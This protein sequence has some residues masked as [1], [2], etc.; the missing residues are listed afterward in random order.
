MNTNP[1]KSPAELLGEIG[2]KVKQRRLHEGLTQATLADKAG[3]SR[4]SL[5]ELEAGRGSQLETFVRVL[6]AMGLDDNLAATIP[7]PRVSPMSMLNA[8]K[9][10]K[11]GYR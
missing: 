5:I 10:R 9:G 6:K 11:R 3:V 2:E 7:V 1:I 4:R 8:A